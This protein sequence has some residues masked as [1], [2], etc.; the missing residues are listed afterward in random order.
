MDP[1]LSDSVLPAHDSR[2]V[3]VVGAG[4]LGRRIALM[5]ASRGGTVR[6]HDPSAAQ[7]D[8]AEEYV[9][10]TLPGVVAAREGASP[11]AVRTTGDLASA[12][13]DAWLVIE[14]VPE[15]LGLKRRVFGD[16]DRLSPPDAVLASNSSSFAS[17]LLIDHVTRPQRVMNAHFYMPPEQNVVEIM[18]CGHTRRALLDHLLTVL[19]SYGLHP[20]EARQESTGF[21]NNRI[22]AAIKREALQVVADGVATAQEVDRLIELNTG[23]PG[24]F[25]A[26]DAI[27]LDVVLAIENHYASQNPHLPS[28]PRTLLHT[29]VDMGHLG[30][31]TG[32]GFYDDYPNP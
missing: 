26:M 20:F 28:S 21:I 18:T 8:A 13:A 15:E 25:R 16:L 9:R 32:R 7:R 11:G 27:G 6:I 23:A 31:K 12:L 30:V 19:P 14:A 29:Y 24:P 4:T 1:V 2:P 22:W 17:R 10:Q 3:A 5:L